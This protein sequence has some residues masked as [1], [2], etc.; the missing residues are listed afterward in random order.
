M[1][2]LFNGKVKFQ[3]LFGTFIYYGRVLKEDRHGNRYIYN[4]DFHKLNIKEYY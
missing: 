3:G 2:K 4:H 1:L